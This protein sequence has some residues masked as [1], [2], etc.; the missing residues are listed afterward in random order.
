MTQA[1]FANLAAF[2][3]S[4][5][6]MLVGAAFGGVG[7]IP[8]SIIFGFIGYISV[9]YLTGLAYDYGRYKLRLVSEIQVNL[10]IV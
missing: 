8:L 9:R 10:P 3:C 7:A 2:G 5:A 4:I 6:G 1:G